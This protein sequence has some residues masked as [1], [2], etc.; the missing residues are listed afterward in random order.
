MH[1]LIEKIAPSMDRLN[2]VVQ[3]T[4]RIN[5]IRNTLLYISHI[6]II[7]HIIHL[8]QLNL[9]MI[10]MVLDHQMHFHFMIL[11]YVILHNM[12]HFSMIYQFN[13]DIIPISLM[14]LLKMVIVT[15]L[16]KLINLWLYHLNN[17]D[18]GLKSQL[19]RMLVKFGLKCWQIVQRINL[20]LI[21]IGH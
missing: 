6:L 20:V 5:M 16:M 12:D 9:I 15:I 17:Y 2:L 11:I 14:L 10:L 13:L 21:Y 3:I 7:I 18:G 8:I 1:R 19:I 4:I